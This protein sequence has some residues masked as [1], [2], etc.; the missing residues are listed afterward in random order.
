[1]PLYP[2]QQAALDQLRQA[3]RDKHRAVILRAPTSWGKTF[4]AAEII[5][6]AIAK[7]GIIWWLVH[8]DELITQA[9]DDFT[10][11]G[12]QC[13]TIRGGHIGNIHARVQVASIQTIVNRLDNLPAPTLIIFDEAHHCAADSWERVLSRYP[14]VPRLGLTATPRRHDGKGL[15]KWFNIIVESPDEAALIELGRLAPYRLL[16]GQAE[17]DL[18]GVRKTAGDWNRADLFKEL[19]G[20]KRTADMV[21]HYGDVVLPLKYRAIGFAVNIQDSMELTD[22]FNAAGIRAAHI[23]G[24]MDTNERRR[25]FEAFKAHKL[26]VLMNVALFGE[27]VHA[28]GVRCVIDGCPTQSLSVVKQRWGR[29]FKYH[30]DGQ[31]AIFLDHANNSFWRI[32]GELI[33]NHGFPDKPQMWTLED[34]PKRK[35]N[36]VAPVATKGCPQCLATV[37]ASAG[38]CSC[39]YVFQ[40]NTISPKVADGVLVEIDPKTAKVLEKEAKAAAKAEAAE[41]RRLQKAFE[42]DRKRE[43]ASQRR[44]AEHA[45]KTQ[46]ELAALY[47]EWGYKSPIA[48]ASH[49]WHAMAAAKAARASRA[50]RSA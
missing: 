37:P 13:S 11:A 25:A 32:N 24:T 19:R 2:D 46:S 31:P 26:D 21:E 16:I 27:G 28:P 35:G 43:A 50:R 41:N 17:I 48:A 45:C 3:F 30:P 36:G 10:S 18:S 40:A 14:D 47:T 4:T 38:R 8:R 44:R 1:M 6:G 20:V 5:R 34:Q 29:A 9:S 12:V 49:K 33:E 7:G 42:D 39:G 15:G 22:S 23:D